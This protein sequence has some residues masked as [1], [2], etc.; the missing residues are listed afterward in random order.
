MPLA[1]FAHIAALQG[2]PRRAVRLGGAAA[3]Q[4]ESSSTPLIPLFEALLTEGLEMAR[5]AL[6]EE[7]YAAAW[8]E[9][10]LLS[11]EDAVAEALA[12]EVAPPAEVPA[13]AAVGDGPFADL[14]AAEVQILRLLA[15]G[16]TTRE[17]AAELVVAVSTV[18]RHITHIY[19]KLGV[20]NRAAATAFALTNG[21]V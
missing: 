12:I 6:G 7:A 20:R 16:R 14:T 18:D 15:A 9:G 19:E 21:L 17:I 11:V 8:A 10:R 2:E 1:G 5:R 3:A 4:T 13:R